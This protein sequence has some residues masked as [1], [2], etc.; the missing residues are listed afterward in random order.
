MRKGR[1]D[2]AGLPQPARASLLA[3]AGGARETHTAR[4]NTAAGASFFA[5]FYTSP[6]PSTNGTFH[7]KRVTGAVVCRQRTGGCGYTQ[8]VVYAQAPLQVRRG[9]RTNS[10]MSCDTNVSKLFVRWAFD[11][12]IWCLLP[13]LLWCMPR[14]PLHVWWLCS[15]YTAILAK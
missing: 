3:S 14:L 4:E 8:R 9:G 1:R 11:T 13:Q 12:S 6:S 10:N 5:S 15:I 2:Q 7:T